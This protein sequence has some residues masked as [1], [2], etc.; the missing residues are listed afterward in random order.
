M[1]STLQSPDHAAGEAARDC[2]KSLKEVKILHCPVL[3]PPP[4]PSMLSST[5]LPH[6]L[7]SL[8]I[9]V[10]GHRKGRSNQ[11]PTDPGAG[12]AIESLLPHSGNGCIKLGSTVA[13]VEGGIHLPDRSPQVVSHQLMI[14][15][16]GNLLCCC[17]CP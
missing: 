2:F 15:G 10:S 4:L 6:P 9:Y 14:T 11:F 16:R 13:L 5:S 3:T 8:S 7:F 17:Y 12:E 1:I